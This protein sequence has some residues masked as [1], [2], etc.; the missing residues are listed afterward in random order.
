MCGFHDRP[1]IAC[2]E[3]VK[4]KQPS[5]FQFDKQF[6][7]GDEH[8]AAHRLALERF[9]RSLGSIFTGSKH[10][11]GKVILVVVASFPASWKR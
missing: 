4:F 1:P 9:K 3:A 2:V 7:I 8:I 10:L 5:L 11:E 6:D